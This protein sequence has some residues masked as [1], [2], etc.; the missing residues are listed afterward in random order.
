MT[1]V[2]LLF[3]LLLTPSALTGQQPD[4]AR[5]LARADA[6]LRAGDST[7]ARAAYRQLLRYDP[8]HSRAT[9]Q[10]A[11]LE[12][13]GSAEQLRLLRRYTKLEPR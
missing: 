13:P 1:R 11:Q 3:G 7:A 9:Y 6:A 10:L 8:D 4:A 5:S 12:P 2:V